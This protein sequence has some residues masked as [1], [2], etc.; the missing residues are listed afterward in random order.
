MTIVVRHLRECYIPVEGCDEQVFITKRQFKQL[1]DDFITNCEQKVARGEIG[2]DEVVTGPAIVQNGGYTE[3]IAYNHM[4][5]KITSARATCGLDDTFNRRL[6]R[7]I[8][9]NRLEA[10]LGILAAKLTR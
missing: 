5:M 9:L 4:G 2:Y 3:A 8:A 10:K 7:T 1:C 6:G